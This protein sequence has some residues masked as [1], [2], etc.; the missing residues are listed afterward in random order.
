MFNLTRIILISLFLAA[1]SGTEEKAATDKTDTAST[2]TAVLSQAYGNGRITSASKL[3]QLASPASGVVMEIIKKENETVREGDILATLNTAAEE[4]EISRIIAT[5]NKQRAS[6][7]I[8]SE[9]VLESEKK[10][11]KRKR[12]YERSLALSKVNA[13]TQDALESASLE[14]EL[15]KSNLNNELNEKKVTNTEL[16][17]LNA[18]LKIAKAKRD[19][20]RIIAP[21]DGKVLE[22]LV[23]KGEG[24]QANSSVAQF[25]PKGALIATCEIDELLADELRLGQSVNVR[26]QDGRKLIS[27]G[28]VIYLSDFLKR[29]SIFG[30]AASE[31][32]DR[33]VRTVEISLDQQQ[34]LLI[35][36]RV[37]CEIDLTQP[38]TK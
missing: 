33:R 12:D 30:D 35:N 18:Q 32:E 27:T 16:Q 9:Q 11:L 25:A 38:T 7:K 28:K 26:S 36:S 17:A 14:Y 24:T 23:T 15:E 1:C 4:A 34:N 20:K 22:W 19:E 21:S 31:A 2:S 10:L 3:A 37:Q 5:I 13:E 6:N 8:A 29:K